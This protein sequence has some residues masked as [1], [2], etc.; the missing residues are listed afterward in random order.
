MFVGDEARGSLTIQD[1]GRLVSGTGSNNHLSN[2]SHIGAFVAA[3]GSIATITG[4]KSRWVHNGHLEIARFGGDATNPVELRVLDGG[5]GEFSYIF[6]TPNDGSR[7]K[8]TVDGAGSKLKV[9]DARGDAGVVSPGFGDIRMVPSGSNG[10]SEIFVT[11]GGLLDI[12]TRL[13][14]G[15]GTADFGG[16][17]HV[18]VDGADSTLNVG[19]ELIVGLSGTTASLTI[20]DGA[21]VNSGTNDS[22]VS[23][24]RDSFIS[25]TSGSAT[26]TVGAQAG[27]DTGHA[28]ATWNIEG[29]LYVAGNQ[30]SD[31]NGNSGVLNI[32]PTGRVIVDGFVRV[33]DS[34]QINLN[35]GFLAFDSINLDDEGDIA[36]V[37]TLNFNSGTVRFR[38]SPGVTF[39]STLLEQLLGD[40][41]T[42]NAGQHLAA[43]SVATLTGPLRLNGG[44]LTAGTMA[45]A[46]IA[47]IDFDAGQF[48]LTNDE[49]TVFNGQ[50]FDVKSGL[51]IN[52]PNDLLKVQLNAALNVLGSVSAEGGISNGQINAINATLTFGPTGLDSNGELNLINT[53]INGPVNLAAGSSVEVAGGATFNGS[54]TGPANFDGKGV[55][56]F[57]DVYSPGNSPAAVGFGGGFELGATGNLRIEIGGTT[58]GS[59]NN[60]HAQVNV[61]DT[62]MLDGTLT[63]ALINGFTPTIGQVLTVVTADE[64]VGD[65]DDWA[66]DVASIDST[67]AIVPVVDPATDEVRLVVT[68]PGDANLDFKVDAG[69][70][71]TLALNWQQAVDD[72]FEADF[73]NDGFVN[74]GD[75]NLL[76]INWQVG[77]GANLAG[78][79]AFEDA[80]AAALASASI[81]EPGV[82]GL[83][84]IGLAGIATRRRA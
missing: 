74:A 56:R 49:F 46:S 44:A 12:D 27:M 45:P 31:N 10:F 21:T 62:A 42:L 70:L 6:T 63:L 35:G 59:S 29:N 36:G 52:L 58:P 76:A 18:T 9:R 81:P 64:L 20:T 43:N 55:V 5:Y 84:A 69:D 66:G 33:W 60:N 79:G 4:E 77:V 83:I 61:A 38:T 51:A 15:Q 2:Q 41:P 11:D 34:G 3:D 37:P 16:Q 1:G 65:F 32:N 53:V 22:V 23:P 67:T 30:A 71:N 26:A 50:T 40:S 19:N 39:D 47:M 73:N 7:S 14:I 24:V 72:W 54:V 80:W 57:N 82:A 28:D 78:A 17:A 68:A 25:H 75:L 8:I 13:A 48:T